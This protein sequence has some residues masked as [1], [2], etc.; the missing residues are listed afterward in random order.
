MLGFYGRRKNKKV[1]DHIQADTLKIY[2]VS[3]VSQFEGKPMCEREI[4]S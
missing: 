3:K 1:S 2:A 4:S